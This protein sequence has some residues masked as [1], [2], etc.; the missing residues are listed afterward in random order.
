MQIYII[1]KKQ[2]Q[3]WLIK[4]LDLNLIDKKQ[5]ISVKYY[6]NYILIFYKYFVF[7][8]IKI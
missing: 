3:I 2:N 8:L 7:Y 6:K 4:I 1:L 5:K